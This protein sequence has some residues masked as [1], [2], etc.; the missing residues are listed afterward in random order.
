MPNKDVCYKVDEWK[1]VPNEGQIHF[2]TTSI[3]I[4][5]RLGKLLE[6]FCLN[7]KSTHTRDELIEDVWEGSILTDQVVT[8]A[9]FELRKILKKH[10]ESGSN[11]IVTVPKR[12]YRFE[13]EITIEKVAAPQ[14]AETIVE[15]SP[16]VVES[17]VETKAD[18]RTKTNEPVE[19]PNQK[20]S[21]KP[22]YVIAALVIALITQSLFLF[23]T[24]STHNEESNTVDQAQHLSHYEFRYAVFNV[25]E[26]LKAKPELYGL[27]IKFIEHI[28]FYSNVRVVKSEEHQRLAAIEFSFS[29]T[30]SR[31]GT[32]ERLLVQYHNRVSGSTHL[33]RR[34]STNFGR[35]HETFPSMID[36]ML[37]A[38][39]IEV[40]EEELAT[41]VDVFPRDESALKALMSATGVS[42]RNAD[43][44]TAI[45]YFRQAKTLAPDNAYT[46]AVNYIGEIMSLFNQDPENQAQQIENLNREYS[47][48]LASVLKTSSNP[49]VCEANA[50]IALT[51]NDPE[52]ASKILLSIPYN[53]QTSLTYLLLA[54]AEE[55]RGNRGGARELYLQATQN[56]SSPTALRLAG[57]MFFDSNLDAMIEEL[58]TIKPVI[59]P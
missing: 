41:N 5:N 3:T 59:E 52:K 28:G 22:Y 2:A 38:M 53:Q 23:T 36:D 10:S 26:E 37:R 51:E 20:P 19:K 43:F 44:D 29:T 48:A 24:R 17:S 35:F 40:S 34:Y 57:P 8:Q 47:E 14:I 18:L 21:N 27:V 30:L 4:D 56:T 55:A 25:S 45:E 9:V 33:N 49:R 39:Y 32:K 1:F 7:P 50:I 15:E 6:F 42:Y 31:D 54:K 46:I 13:A 58:Q 12:G 16:I 11:Y